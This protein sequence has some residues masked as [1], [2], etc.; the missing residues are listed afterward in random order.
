MRTMLAR[1][2]GG[3]ALVTALLAWWLWPPRGLQPLASEFTIHSVTMIQPGEGHRAP[4][5]LTI[6]GGSIAQIEPV[7]AG[8]LPAVAALEGSFVLPGLIDM[9]T[10]LP[11]HTPLRLTE[12]FGILYALH[13]V[14]SVRDAGDI[15]GTAVPAAQQIFERDG[16][17]GPRVFSCGPFVAGGSP[18]FSNTVIVS[19]PAEAPDIARKLKR[20]GR[21]CMKLYDGLDPPRIRA[22]AA[23]ARAEGLAPIGHVPFGLVVENAGVP[24]VQHLMGTARPETIAA[25]DQIVHR[26]MDWG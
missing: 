21:V 17:V 15:D 6:S 22:L 26:V 13:G 5:D 24:E 25:G 23:A 19:E 11:P 4:V 20:E 9:H 18:R 1:V 3:V 2:V 14:T 7:G 16:F 8:R 10:H 12:L